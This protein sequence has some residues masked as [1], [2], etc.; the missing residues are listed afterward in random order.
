M[1]VNQQDR[2]GVSKRRSKCIFE[3]T[4]SKDKEVF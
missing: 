1:K 3:V 4:E 2:I